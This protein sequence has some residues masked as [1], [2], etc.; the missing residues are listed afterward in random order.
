MAAQQQGYAPG[1]GSEKNHKEESP[2]RKTV[3]KLKDQFCNE[4]KT[5]AGDLQEAE[6]NNK[7]LYKI[8]HQKKC[9][10]V[11]TEQNYR[12]TRNLELT[13]GVELMQASQEMTNNLTTY[14]ADNKAILTALNNIVAATKTAK[15]KFSELR[16]AASKLDACRNDSCNK[17]QVILLTGKRQDDCGDDAPQPPCGC[18]NAASI[19]DELVNVPVVFS[20][21]IDTIFGASA[22]VVG[23][24]TF[25][26]IAALAGFQTD[27]AAKAKAFDDFVQSKQKAGETDLQT[28]QTELVK[29]T[30]DLTQ[31]EYLL[32][33]K[34]DTL[35]AVIG[36]K[37]YLC[38]DHCECVSDDEDRFKQCKC[39]ICE[40][41]QE[42]MD[43][44]C[45]DKADCSPA[46][47]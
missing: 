2:T 22:D 27:L 24:Q 32:Y 34:R 21:D 16:D 25:S 5:L 40:I 38:Q 26:N 7:G 33:N 42:V 4:L 18:E 15:A 6:E 35:D 9:A 44:Y 46:A 47:S 20:R 37:D 10:F 19:L 1:R 8:Y 12:I 23:I 43:I 17:S 30:R 45:S 39:E 28:A 13:V 31:S 29:A 41:S 3:K 11:K 36:I 14:V